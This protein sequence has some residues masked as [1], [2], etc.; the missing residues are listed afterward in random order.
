MKHLSIILFL[1]MVVVISALLLQQEVDAA[2][3][4]TKPPHYDLIIYRPNDPEYHI[5]AYKIGDR[6]IIYD[7]DAALDACVKACG[8]QEGNQ[9]KIYPPPATTQTAYG[10]R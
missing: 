7:A 6:W 8:H 2:A 4:Q 9:L 5:V 1:V 3:T 10:N